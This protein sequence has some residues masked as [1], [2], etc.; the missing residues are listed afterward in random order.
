LSLVDQPLVGACN[1]ASP[2]RQRLWSAFASSVRDNLLAEVAVQALRVGGVIVLARALRPEDFGL[3][4]MLVV[5]SI[6][7][8]L[9][10]EGGVPD[11][12][13]QREL[14]RRDHEITAWWATMVLAVVASAGL[15]IVAPMLAKLMAMP[16]LRLG[17]RLICLPLLLQGTATVGSARLRRELRFGALALAD[18][19]GE[20]A[21]LTAALVLLAKGMAQWSLAGALAARLAA[22]ALTIWAADLRIPYGM[23]RIAAM[24]ELIRFA[25]G[26]CG[27]QVTTALSANADYLLVGG[28]LGGQALGFY[29]MAWD[30]L[31]FVPDRLHRVAG[32]VALPAFCRLQDSDSELGRAYLN[33][34]NYVGRAV[35]P[36]LACAALAAPE[37]IGTIYGHQWLPV[38]APMRLLTVG[39]ALVGLRIGI[40]SVFYTK[41]YPALDIYL[42][43]ARLLLL[44][45]VVFAA[46]PAGLLGVSV[47]VSV[48][49]TI[50]GF[51]GQYLVI[52]LVGLTTG[53]VMSAVVPGAR[54]A[55][56]CLLATAA[57]KLVAMACG[58]EPPWALLPIALAPTITFF[59]AQAGDLAEI[60]GR[61]LG[62]D[63]SAMPQTSQQET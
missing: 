39:L 20:V 49:E 9:L 56:W 25:L 58:L 24:R 62:R 35:L 5:A 63:R 11:A 34:V 15:W 54:L 60:V 51:V 33:F 18:V 53:D 14:L 32:R 29:A 48:V 10:S 22:R 3:L 59:W 8:T 21:F 45:I 16:R 19:L 31:R 13:I 47:G 27:G 30:L 7:A 52:S 43:G 44:V 28:L 2:A 6:F 55:L 17:L 50:I 40:G 61:G 1:I 37:L 38:V 36:M 4:K 57:G 42:N 41:N 26:A 23:P 12:L 46:A